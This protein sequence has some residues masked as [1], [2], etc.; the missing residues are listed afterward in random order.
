[1][2]TQQTPPSPPTPPAITK[3]WVVEKDSYAYNDEYITSA[4]FPGCFYLDETKAKIS[5]GYQNMQVLFDFWDW[6]WP[7]KGSTLSHSLEDDGWDFGDEPPTEDYAVK[8]PSALLDKVYGMSMDEACMFF[9]DHD[10]I[11]ALLDEVGYELDAE[12]ALYVVC[13]LTL[14]DD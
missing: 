11:E 7:P 3:V 14:A 2:P 4:V 1:M 10:S 9:A 6:F 8:Q 13:E 5:A 12:T